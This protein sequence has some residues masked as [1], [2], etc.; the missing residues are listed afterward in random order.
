M[1]EL[2]HAVDKKLHLSQGEIDAYM[3]LFEPWD[4]NYKYHSNPEMKAVCEAN[5]LVSA[6]HGELIRNSYWG[7]EDLRNP[8]VAKLSRGI[9]DKMYY[10]PANSPVDFRNSIYNPD[11]GLVQYEVSQHYDMQS[12][13]ITRT[14]TNYDVRVNGLPLMDRETLDLNGNRIRGGEFS[15]SESILPFNSQQQDPACRTLTEPAASEMSSL[16]QLAQRVL[17]SSRTELDQM[18]R[19][20]ANSPLGEQFRQRGAELWEERQAELRRQEQEAQ[21]RARQQ[22]QEKAQQHTPR[23]PVMRL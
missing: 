2:I 13:T 23:G 5:A 14:L 3:K 21:E 15:L 12:G 22:E 19:D 20:I 1:H 11:T 8:D 17:N 4:E 16:S 10:I 7:Q 6:Q 9:T 18:G